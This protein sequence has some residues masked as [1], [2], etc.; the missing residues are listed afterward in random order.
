M[1]HDSSQFSCRSFTMAKNL[2]I[3]CLLL[4]AI[5]ELVSS[6]HFRGG[7]IMVRPQPGGV[8]NEVRELVLWLLSLS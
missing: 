7:I 8:E 1:Q 6:T 2:G 3:L 4:C 5:I